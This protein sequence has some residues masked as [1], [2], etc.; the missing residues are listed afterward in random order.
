MQEITLNDIVALVSKIDRN[1]VY[2]GQVL[3]LSPAI[4][5]YVP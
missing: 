4:K 1:I 3:E 2:L 5:V